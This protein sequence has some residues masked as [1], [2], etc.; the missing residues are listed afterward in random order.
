MNDCHSQAGRGLLWVLAAIPRGRG[1]C[2]D[3]PALCVVTVGTVVGCSGRLCHIADHRETVDRK[4]QPGRGC[5]V[6]LEPVAG[7]QTENQHT[8]RG[9]AS[10]SSSAVTNYHKRHGLKQRRF[11]LLQFW[12]PEVW[13]GSHG[14]NVKVMAGLRSFRRLKGRI[15]SLPFAALKGCCLPWL[16]DP[17]SSGI[18]PTSASII[19][20]LL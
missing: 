15:C 2:P 11:I 6:L 12:R 17:S 13:N 5:G 20:L 8:F 16:A 9:T 14:A 3:P 7:F 18:I 10:V 1:K 19:N 4:L